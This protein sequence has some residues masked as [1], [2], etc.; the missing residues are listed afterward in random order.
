MNACV[1]KRKRK[2]EQLQNK[3]FIAVGGHK[4]SFLCGTFN[5]ESNAT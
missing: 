1:S 5:Y 4:T 2:Q 3:N